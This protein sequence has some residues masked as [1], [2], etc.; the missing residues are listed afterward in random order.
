MSKC[1]KRPL[2]GCAVVVSGSRAASFVHIVPAIVA[3][4]M[5]ITESP[6]QSAALT[7]A[8]PKTIIQEIPT[9]AYKIELVPIPGDPG[10]GIAP[11]HL[12]KTEVTWDAFDVYVYSLDAAPHEG[13]AGAASA[14]AVTRPSKPYLPPDRGFGHEG[15]AAICL[16][17]KNASE[18]CKWL[19]AK[20]GRHYRL[21]TA[22]EW[23]HACRAGTTTVY[24][25]GDDPQKLGEYAWFDANA[26]GK[27]QPVGSKKPNAWGLFDMHG[28]VS[29]W[30]TGPDGKPLT[31]GGSY[32]DSAEH[33]TAASSRP[34]SS[35][36]NASD[37]QIPKS[38]WWLSDGPF[39][40]FRIVLDPSPMPSEANDPPR[41][42]APGANGLPASSDGDTKK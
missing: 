14:D 12:S 30:V 23:E 31:K 16:S 36:W 41:D 8:A 2:C 13:E 22:A 7:E 25:F 28:N 1:A 21:P 26:D 17:Y 9:A 39:V 4:M 6:G 33:L 11:F 42:A 18:F 24:S 19:S 29:E 20:S 15:Y 10:K 32:R 37:P 35:A 3:A 5:I 34:Q 40:G 27:T 38:P